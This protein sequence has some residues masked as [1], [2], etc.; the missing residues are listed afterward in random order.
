MFRQKMDSAAAAAAAAGCGQAEAMMAASRDHARDDFFRGS[1]Y[2][3]RT[4][5]ML[6]VSS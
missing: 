2:L 6:C 5:V 3:F 1:G 4:D